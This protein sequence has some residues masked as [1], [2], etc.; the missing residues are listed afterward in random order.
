MAAPSY[1]T[2]VHSALTSPPYSPSVTDGERIVELRSSLSTLPGNLPDEYVFQSQRIKLD[3]GARIWPTHTPCYGYT[4]AVEGTV[5]VTSLDHVKRVKVTVGVAAI[6]G[7]VGMPV[8]CIA[9][10]SFMERGVLAGHIESTLFQRAVTLYTNHPS[11]STATT[12]YPFSISFPTTG[13]DNENPLPPSF[14]QF[15]PGVSAEIRYRIRVDMSRS[16]LRRR[17]RW[18]VNL[19]YWAEVDTSLNEPAWSYPFYTFLVLTPLQDLIPEDESLKE[20]HLTPKPMVKPS[21]KNKVTQNTEVQA[22]IALPC[23]L[24]IASGDRIPFVLTVQ[25]QSPALAALYTNVTLQLIK[26]IKVKAYEKT[27]TKETVI[28]AGEVYDVEQRGDG[29][30]I[31]RGELGNGAPGRELSWT[32][33]GLV[34]IRVCMSMSYTQVVDQASPVYDGVVVE[35]SNVRGYYTDKDYDAPAWS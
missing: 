4:S 14:V 5:F 18:V 2:S 25:S 33:G 6:F 24:V 28:S 27:S 15:L 12:S 19:W 32:A 8:E 10:A 35:Y 34:E 1:T 17:E 20:L 13:D 29:V 16:G 23:P 26:H 22:K 7:P 30:Q 3:L 9:K 11:S 31:L 21:S